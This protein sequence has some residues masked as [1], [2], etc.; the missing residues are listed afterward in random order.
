M[1]DH[2][3][4]GRLSELVAYVKSNRIDVIFIAP[5]RGGGF[6]RSWGEPRAHE[7]DRG[8]GH[9]QHRAQDTRSPEELD[10]GVE[11]APRQHLGFLRA[12]RSDYLG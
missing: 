12:E 2:L 3:L 6:A 10:L 5:V 11:S 8:R 9:R 4:L 1:G 7:A